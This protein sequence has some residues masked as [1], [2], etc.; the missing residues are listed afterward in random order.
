VTRDIPPLNPLRVFECV[1]R[2]KSFSRAAEELCV[3]PSAV[4]RQVSL[5]E[6]Y[7]GMPFFHRDRAGIRLTDE[8]QRYLDDIGPAF[9]QIARATKRLAAGRKQEPLRLRVYSTFAAKWLVRRLARFQALHPDIRLRIVTAI[10]PVDFASEPVDASIQ[11]GD[12]LWPDVQSRLLFGD[13][14]RPVAK[15]DLLARMP[16]QPRDLLPL[17]RIHSHYR[18]QDWP[19]WLRSAGV[20]CPP[21]AEPFMLPSSLLAYQAAVDGLGVAMAQ[22]RM[23]EAELASGALAFLT[24]HVLRRPLGHFLVT[25]L[26]SL[27][28]EK[29]DR[30]HGWLASEIG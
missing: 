28:A 13:E 5:L 17:R 18:A 16:G 4:S 12:G 1:A 22:T 8:G 30:L 24:D 21:E 25:P 15:P 23:V 27:H 9:E 29:I 11:F 3:S 6:D 20:D 10:A 26:K 2:L 14:L 19:D 7:L